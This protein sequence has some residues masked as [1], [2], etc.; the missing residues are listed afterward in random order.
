MVDALPVDRPTA[1]AAGEPLMILAE[2]AV[3]SLTIQVE[4]QL[5]PQVVP[6]APV[7]ISPLFDRTQAWTGVVAQV[8]EKADIINCETVVAVLVT[9]EA[10]LPGAGYTV[11]AKVLPVNG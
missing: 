7:L 2:T 10:D 3:H 4:E 1:F 5:V 6:G 11:I 8:S 9:T